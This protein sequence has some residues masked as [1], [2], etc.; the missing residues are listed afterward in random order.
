[1]HIPRNYLMWSCRDLA[2][3]RPG[4]RSI[5]A[6]DDVLVCAPDYDWFDFGSQFR[7]F[8]HL[9]YGTFSVRR[10][11]HSSELPYVVL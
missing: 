4:V 1:M 6:C 11:A 3:F 8:F 2:T 5:D 9:N 10:H 7:D